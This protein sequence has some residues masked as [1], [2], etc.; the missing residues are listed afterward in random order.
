M[1]KLSV[2]YNAHRWNDLRV[3]I[4]ERC[5]QITYISA[6]EKENKTL[7]LLTVH[8]Q[9]LR[10]VFCDND[11]VGFTVVMSS[12]VHTYVGLLLQKMTTT[13]VRGTSSSKSRQHQQRQQK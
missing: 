7:L 6:K 5:N 4:N 10:D 8:S 1:I 13:T 9:N 11:C 3:T 12:A 2:V